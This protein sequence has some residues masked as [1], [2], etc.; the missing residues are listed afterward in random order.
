MSK[1]PERYA[2]SCGPATVSAITGLTRS[3]AAQRLYDAI[4]FRYPN[5]RVRTSTPWAAQRAVYEEMGYEI[6]ESFRWNG[7]A[8]TLAQWCRERRPGTWAIATTTHALAYRDGRVIEDNGVPKRRGRMK[9]AFRFSRENVKHVGASNDAWPAE[10]M[11][12]FWRDRGGYDKKSGRPMPDAACLQ[13]YR[14]G[15]EQEEAGWSR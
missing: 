10:A 1:H 4:K 2:R 14:E 9:Y 7:D 5:R 3:E 13:A 12:S 15:F 11:L 8:P 6:A